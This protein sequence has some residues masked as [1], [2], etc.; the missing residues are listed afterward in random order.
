MAI[1]FYQQNS[2]QPPSPG[3]ENSGSGG[4]GGRM[5]VGSLFSGIGGIDLGLER[6]GM[7]VVWQVEKDA[8][9]NKIL[10]RYW[11]DVERYGPIESVDFNRATPVDILAGGDPCPIRSR[12]RSNGES[13]HP[14]LSGYFPR[15]V[16]NVVPKWVLR[17]NV[18]APDAKE[19]QLGLECL[20]YRTLNIEIDAAS[21]TGQQRIR[22]FII[23]CHKTGQLFEILRKGSWK[24]VKGNYSPRLGTRPVT[25]ALTCHR[26]RYDSRDCYIYDGQTRILDGDERQAL[27]G[28][29]PGWLDGLSERRIAIM[30]GN[31]VVP[32]VAEWIGRRIMEASTP[33]P[34]AAKCQR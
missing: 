9:C 34:G 2:N 6:A 33:T 11:P 4:A 3:A 27:A 32:Q 30:T 17:E 13:R 16:A 10:E 26:T 22:H 7:K 20:G 14:D 31:S 21:F 25:P 8:Y 28:F 19:F 12:A 23:G 1:W 5:K 18:P 29:P 24:I 15:A